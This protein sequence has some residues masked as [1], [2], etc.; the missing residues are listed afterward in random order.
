[1]SALCAPNLVRRVPG[2]PARAVLSAAPGYPPSPK[3]GAVFPLM[4]DPE[5][6]FSAIIEIRQIGKRVPR[7]QRCI[8]TAVANPA[9]R[10]WI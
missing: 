7:W 3:A 9:Q 2:A 6:G 1:L 10:D 5:D 8:H 4:R